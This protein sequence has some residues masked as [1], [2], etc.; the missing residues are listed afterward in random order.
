M[1]LTRFGVGGGGGHTPRPS[2]DAEPLSEALLLAT[3]LVSD[4]S[5]EGRVDNSARPKQTMLGR[6]IQ[7]KGSITCGQTC[8][9]GLWSP[10]G[11]TPQS[12][13]AKDGP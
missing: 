13:A 8:S 1:P 5:P 10:K 3:P 4:V 12:Q 7:G 2:G 11:N 9:N 6:M